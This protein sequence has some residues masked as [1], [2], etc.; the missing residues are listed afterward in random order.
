MEYFMIAG[1]CSPFD[2]LRVRIQEE[3]LMLSLSKHEAASAGR[4]F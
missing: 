4:R 3:I 2:K 1:C